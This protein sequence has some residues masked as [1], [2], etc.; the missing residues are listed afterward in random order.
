M[1]RCST[2]AEANEVA[3]KLAKLHTGRFEVVGVTRRFHGATIGARGSTYLDRAAGFGP[4]VPGTLAVPAPYAYRCPIRHCDATATAP[5]STRASSWST[6]SR[7]ARSAAAICEPVLS[8]GGVIV[9]PDGWLARAAEHCA[10]RGMLLIVDE[11][12]T[13]LGRLRRRVRH[14]PRR[15][16]CPIS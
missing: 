2:G 7:W 3:L 12:Q 14:R 6:S 13:G 9:P 11:A 1:I 15:A 8:T 4:L 5:A 10:S 16:S